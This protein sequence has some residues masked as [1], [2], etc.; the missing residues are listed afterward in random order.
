VQEESH[1]LLRAGLAQLLAQGNQVIVVHPDEI[2]RLE[3]DSE[4]TR[5]ALIGELV[6]VV[7]LVGIVEG[8]EKVVE[9]RPEDGVA[10]AEIVILVLAW[11]Q[12]DG[13]VGDVVAAD[14][15][16]GPGG[17]FHDLAIPA[18]PQ[19]PA[20]LHGRKQPDRKAARHSAAARNG[21]SIGYGYE[22]AHDA[23]SHDRLRRSA[24]VMMP[25]ML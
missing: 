25:T 23:S 7:L 4:L 15:I 3:E 1:R 6:G 16:R 2:V 17:A 10:E 12:L 22:T 11:R 8:V 21:N 19:A 14:D 20:R 5:E 9:H 13:R 24:L 18:E